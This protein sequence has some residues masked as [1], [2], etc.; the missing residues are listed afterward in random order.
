MIAQLRKKFV[1][2]AFVAVLTLLAVILTVINLVNFG[3]V[4]ADA[5]RV[6]DRLVGQGGV[7]GENY[8]PDNGI[9]QDNAQPNPPMQQGRPEARQRFVGPDSPELGHTIRYFTVSFDAQGNAV[10]QVDMTAINQQQAVEWAQSL[11]DNKGGWTRTYY[12]YRVWRSGDVTNVTIIDYS[13]ELLPSYRVLIASCVG[14][15][16]GM[17][18]TILVLLGVSRNVVKPIE[19]SNRRQKRFIADAACELKTPIAVIDANRLMLQQRNG[20]CAETDAIA[21]QVGHLTTLVQGLDSVLVLDEPHTDAFENLDL[22]ALTSEVSAPYVAMFAQSGKQLTLQIQPDLS[23]KGDSEKLAEMVGYCL[24]NAL[25][26]AQTT[27]SM[28]LQRVE[29]RLNLVFVNDAHGVVDGPLDSVFER[30]YRSDDVRQSGVDGA[31][32]SLSIVKQIVEIHH[33]RI[34][35]RGDNGNFVLKIEL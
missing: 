25:H 6:L 5:D 7:F 31:G 3:L 26:Y 1:V 8:V 32:L 21:A 34:W 17:I 20:A 13:R 22:S 23:Y 28:S 27:A 29:Q 4:G 30:F 18:V 35:A 11:V 14:V 24:D 19:Q 16:V 33:G 10:A 12:R 9:R 15:A 2:I